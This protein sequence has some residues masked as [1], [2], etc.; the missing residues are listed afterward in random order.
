RVAG[1]LSSWT[2]CHR[3]RTAVACVAALR[4]VGPGATSAREPGG[5]PP[6]PDGPGCHG[7]CCEGPGCD[8]PSG[9]PLDRVA[10]CARTG[11]SGRARLGTGVGAVVAGPGDGVGCCDRSGPGD[12]TGAG[13]ARV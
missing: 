1:P 10:R 12:G 7:P 11:R 4:A 13:A 9:A 6:G 2:G 8:E 5:N 3:T